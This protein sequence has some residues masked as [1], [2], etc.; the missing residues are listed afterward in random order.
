MNVRISSTW[1][2][3]FIHQRGGVV[4]IATRMTAVD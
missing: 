3:D 2:Q 1:L 4:N